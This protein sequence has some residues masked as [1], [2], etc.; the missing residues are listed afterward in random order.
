MLVITGI[1][2]ACGLLI[3]L[4]YVVIPRKVLGLEKTEELSGILPGVNC[5]ACGKPGCFA[6]AQALTKNAG[7]ML[8]T[9]CAPLL[10]DTEGLER[11]EKAL[12]LTLDASAMS[13]KALIHCSGNS[14]VIYNY[15][16]VA[17]CKG[18]ALLL[19]GYKKCPYACL[20]LRDCLEVCPQD[21]ITVKSQ[22]SRVPGRVRDSRLQTVD[23][24]LQGR[25]TPERSISRAKHLQSE[26]SPD[27][28]AVIDLE[29]CNGC[30]LCLVECPLNLIELVPASTKIAFLCN[31]EPLRDIPGR[32]KCDSGCIHC[33]KCYKSCEYGAI[34]WNKERALPE[35][36]IEKCT[37]CRKC[38][39]ACEQNTLADFTLHSDRSVAGIKP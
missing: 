12:G 28:V 24:R 25:G 15:S 35:F 2:L 17:T 7:L 38:I 4:V 29:K 31:Y 26:A 1:G 13:K 9:P 8:K 30:G 11:L 14:G 6:Y 10:Q 37:L 21:A 33:R 5:G 34:V 39:E 27:S 23:S 20:G 16:G 18:A 36:D 22:E 32:E 3:Y 19:G